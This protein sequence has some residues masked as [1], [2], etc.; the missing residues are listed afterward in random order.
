ME[1]SQRKAHDINLLEYLR[2]EGTELRLYVTFRLERTVLDLTGF[3]QKFLKASDLQFHAL[4][5]YLYCYRSPMGWLS[6]CQT[7]Y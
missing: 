6:N 4:G 5:V 7:K 1:N 2:F 3:R